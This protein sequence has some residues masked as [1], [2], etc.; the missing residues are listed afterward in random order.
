[1]SEARAPAEEG[2]RS[3]GEAFRRFMVRPEA[4]ALVFLVVLV[5]VFSLSSDRFLSRSNFE[6]I[7]V[8]VAVLGVIALAVNQVV[9][10]AEIDISTGSMMGLCAVAAGMV[11][12]ST[13]GLVLPLLAAVAVGATAG[14]VNGLLVTLG[15]IPAIIVTLGMLYAL[16]GVILL[17][18][19]GTWITGIPAETRVLGTGSVLGI[20][21]PVII[22]LALFLIMELVSRH[23]TWGRN[24][25]AVGGNRRAA[26][27]AG[28]PINRT[29]FLAFAL[30]GVFVGVASMIYLGRAGSIQTN[31]GTG[32]ELQVIAAVVIGG[33]SIA[34]GRGS[35]LAAL[36]GAV[37]IGVILNGLILLG[38][39]GIWQSAVLGALILFA[40]A[41][42][43]LRRR[44]LGYK[45]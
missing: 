36:T 21:A 15:R 3:L 16:R 28:L 10:C 22:L 27:F 33:T 37:V 40:V 19:G 41:T 4:P 20:D 9:L 12:S 26:R 2:G 11:A 7:V 32:L 8:S 1:M 38:V 44:L 35:A 34:G 25:F 24:T 31:T 39:P 5:A 29:R 23:S 43:V 13:G 6:S 14:A 45:A 18:T 17:V 30:V 42:D